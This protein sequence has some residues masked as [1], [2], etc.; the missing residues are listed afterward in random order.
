MQR[1]ARMAHPLIQRTIAA[2]FRRE[3]AVKCRQ[4]P[5]H[6]DLPDSCHTGAR[7]RRPVL[8]S[9]GSLHLDSNNQHGFRFVT[10][11]FSISAPAAWTAPEFPASGSASSAVGAARTTPGFRVL[12][13]R[14]LFPA[15]TYFNSTPHSNYDISPDGSTFAFVR[16]NP[17]S[18]IV[19][20]Q[21]MPALLRRAESEPSPNAR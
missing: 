20:I 15:S 10:D 7:A 6:P 12:E 19:V 5:V 18:R 16:R 13:R 17:A 9:S 1:P 4:V 14:A 8:I 2:Q 21:N 11:S 3:D